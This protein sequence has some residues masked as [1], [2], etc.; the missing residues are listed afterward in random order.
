MS[1]ELVD[2]P[3][4]VSRPEKRNGNGTKCFGQFREL[5]DSKLKSGGVVAIFTHPC[6]DPDAM[7]SQ[8]SLAW[9]LEKVYG[10]ECRLFLCGDVSHPQNLTMVNLLGTKL[11]PVSEYQDEDYALKVLVD[12]I[13][14]NAGTGGVSVAWDAVIDHH[15]EVPTC[16]CSSTIFINQHTGSCVA[17]IY[18]MFKHF[19][20]RLDEDADGDQ[21]VATAMMVGIMTDTKDQTADRTTNEDQDAYRE[22]FPYRNP[23]AFQK[24]LRFKRSKFW[25]LA[26]AAAVKDAIIEDG[27]AVV[28]L[29]M[30]SGKQRDLVADMA[31]E[32]LTWEGCDL[33]IAFAVV[34][35]HTLQGSIR[36]SSAAVSAARLAHDLG[37]EP[38]NGNG[39]GWGH[40]N[41]AGYRYCLGGLAVSLTEE[42]EDIRE[43]TW[44][45]V[46]KREIKRILKVHKTK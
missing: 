23:T 27:V 31:D 41:A 9:L 3:R 15:V 28:G 14:S 34:D 26:K 21:N 45:L 10:V 29:G 16:E 22:L 19:D 1:T 7:A 18:A 44:A 42:E 2:E 33:A 12:V 35:G 43:E 46:R 5:C 24:I 37:K 32:M 13:P 36:S 4:V 11:I 6:P 17:T 20:I 8:M 30:L 38:K 40:S 25:V 39:N